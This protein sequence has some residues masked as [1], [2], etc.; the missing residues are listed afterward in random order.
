MDAKTQLIV[1]TERELK[2]RAART[3]KQLGIPLGTIINA[4]LRQLVQDKTVT[5]SVA[6]VP[7]P[8]LRRLFDQVDEDVRVGRNISPA[9]NNV[10]AAIAY[11]RT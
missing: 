10:E 6:E 11:L 3:A 2:E 9:F 7:T 4:F 8:A 1:K 5:L